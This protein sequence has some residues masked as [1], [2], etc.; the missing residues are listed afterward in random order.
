MSRVLF[1]LFSPRM[2]DAALGGIP[3]DLAMNLGSALL[4]AESTGGAVMRTLSWS[5]LGSA[6]NSSR[7][8]RGW[9]R[10]TSVTPCGV[11]RMYLGSSTWGDHWR[12]RSARCQAA[13]GVHCRCENGLSPMV[14]LVF[15]IGGCWLHKY[16]AGRGLVDR[17]DETG[18]DQ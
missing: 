17:R 12:L 18:G 8:E 7:E 16:E 3:S 10:M 13:N 15:G 1:R 5:A 4:A 14:Q 9:T 2:R 11:S 6:M